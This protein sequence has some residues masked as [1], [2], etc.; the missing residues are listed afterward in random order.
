MTPNLEFTSLLITIIVLSVHTGYCDSSF[1]SDTPNIHSRLDFNCSGI[2]GGK[3][4]NRIVG[5]QDESLNNHG[6][7]Y[8]YGVVAYHFNES[9]KVQT[10]L[11]ILNDE[12]SNGDEYKYYFEPELELSYRAGKCETAFNGG[13]IDNF[14]LGQGLTVKD[15]SQSGAIG[16]V[17]I[18]G[19]N[20]SVGI[21]SSGYGQ[22]EDL[23]WC[24]IGNNAVPAKLSILLINKQ[25]P[26][27]NIPFGKGQYY[28]TGYLLP[29]FEYRVPPVTL[30]AEYGFKHNRSSEAD[31]VFDKA[32]QNA[33]AGLIGMKTD[34]R[35]RRFI[36]DG[37]IELR[38]CQNG[39]V[40]VTGAEIRRFGHFWNENDSRANWVD[41][42]DSR[43]DFYWAYARLNLRF[44]AT[45]R[46]HVFFRDELLYY[47]SKQKEAI[48]FP[49]TYFEEFSLD[50][51][52]VKYKPSTNFYTIGVT[53][54]P[55]PGVVVE[56]SVKNKLINNPGLWTSIY[57]Q[58]GQ[59][60]FATDHPFFEARAIWNIGANK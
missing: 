3:L 44:I 31:D 7:L 17:R 53:F 51:G 35:T 29:S 50:G 11:R 14:T 39:F 6:Y 58:W 32:P 15:F 24:D 30:Y 41:F 27:S 52:I 59:R 48:V 10:R 18:N 37:C 2:F 4:D 47:Y 5:M 57:S 56:T 25:G 9:V 22:A 34:C 40:P 12:L 43:E 21:F 20:T 60:F 26:M 19:W 55:V 38:A 8:T 33:H 28:V 13:Y 16:K 42:F 1:L 23:Y 36:C 49:G 45:S 54:F 46:W